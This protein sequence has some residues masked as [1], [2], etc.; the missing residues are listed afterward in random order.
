MTRTAHPGRLRVLV[1]FALVYT[2]WGS[3]YLA[4]AIAV[5]RIPPELMTGTRFLTAGTAMLAGCAL[6]GRRLRLHWRDA[7]HA[8][9]VGILLL[10]VSN[11]ILAWAE[12]TLPSGLSALI[13]SVIPL[14]FVVIDTWILRGDHLSRQGSLGLPLG[15]VG[16]VVLLWPKLTAT[17]ALGWKQLLVSLALLGG[18]AVWALGSVLS[19]RW[20]TRLD[21]FSASGWE[22]AFAGLVNLAVAFLS[23]EHHQ[24]VWTAR[25][26]LAILYLV[27]FGSLVGYTAYVWLLQ[28]VSMPKVAT[29]AYVN[30]VV[31]VFLGWWLLHER[32]DRYIL[33]GSAITLA[34]VA[35]VTSANVRTRAGKLE[36]ETLPAVESAGD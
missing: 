7:L 27:I 12:Q 14:F 25:G 21:P 8:A 18:S 24:A 22:M 30:P 13:V 36:P 29:Y 28:N 1:A 16:I 4:I 20:Q 10:S 19:K 3:T 31:A 26:S 15:V 33:A 23:G 32:V 5:E 2:L 34:S 6:A 17:T 11:T 9:V 35:L